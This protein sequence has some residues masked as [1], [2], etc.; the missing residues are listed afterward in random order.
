MCKAAQGAVSRCH[1]SGVA[2]PRAQLLL[3]L[4]WFRFE[5]GQ[6]WNSATCVMSKERPIR[7]RANLFHSRRAFTWCLLAVQSVESMGRGSET[8]G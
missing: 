1:G 5:A 3:S 2:T 7:N 8:H 4:A 6:H